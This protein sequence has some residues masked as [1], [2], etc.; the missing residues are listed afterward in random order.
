MATVQLRNP[1]E[2]RAYFAREKASGKTPNEAMHALKRR[3][4]EI[5]FD[6]AIAHTVTGPGRTPG[7]DY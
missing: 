3:L 4:S 6:D 5:V 1:T 2:G 7:H